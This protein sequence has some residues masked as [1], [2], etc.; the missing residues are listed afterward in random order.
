[1]KPCRSI[2]P[3]VVPLLALALAPACNVSA[4]APPTT[5]GVDAMASGGA[6]DRGVVVL[7]TDFTSTQIALA[8]PDGTPLSPAFLSTASTTASGLAF[9]LS[10][11]AALPGTTPPSGRVVFL[12]RFGT[13]VVTWADPA[14]A[15]VLAQ[16]PVGTG[17]ES[18]PQDYIETDATH[19]YL[20]RWGVNDAPGAQAFDSGSD[21]LVLDT[22]TPNPAITKS[23]AMPV[24][25]G[26][27][28][29]P[30]NMVRVGETT[31]VVLQRTSED[32]ATVGEGAIVGLAN[33]AIAWEIHVTGLKNCGRPALSPDRSR[34][35][36]GC[37]G[38]LALDGSVM[39]A[40]AAAIAIFDVTAMPPVEIRRFAIA[41]QLAAPPQNS[42]AWASATQLVGKTQ[43]ALG[44][45]LN[46]EAFV[47]DTMSGTATVLIAA[48]PDAQ[49]KG[50]G[51]VYGDVA[52]A[53]GCGD[54]CLLAD[55]D[56]GHLRRWKV[57]NGM[58]AALTDVDVDPTVGLPPVSLGGY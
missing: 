14:T 29:R 16:L 3:S 32:F 7:M 31:L 17:F 45:T 9:A 55:S 37:E 20:S 19:A 53:P 12:D 11:D 49:G 33:G 46:N 44:G 23:I 58:F 1:M 39:D 24:E 57:T 43:T 52:C 36:I 10:G 8:A 28:P 6:C 51:V 2:H 30:A 42:V 26:L 25:D 13:N 22:T 41:D 38:Q 4:T 15:K 48:Q 27:P 5:G 40:S 47:L 34:L 54:V 50:K 18:N 56:V 21:V 35:A